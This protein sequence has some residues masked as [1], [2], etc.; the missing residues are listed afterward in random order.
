MPLTSQLRVTTH[1]ETM[2]L[3]YVRESHETDQIKPHRVPDLRTVLPDSLSSMRS[4]DTFHDVR[5]MKD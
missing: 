2:G 4:L 3:I 5:G 1:D